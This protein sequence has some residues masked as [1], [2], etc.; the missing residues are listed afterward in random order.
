MIVFTHDIVFLKMLYDALNARGQEATAVTVYNSHYSAGTVRD[1]LPWAGMNTRARLG[2]LKC[3]AQYAAKVYETDGPQAYDPVAR[4]T[5]G[6]R[7]VPAPTREDPNGRILLRLPK[8]L[9]V[10]VAQAAARDGVSVNAFVTAAV[11]ERVG[12]TSARR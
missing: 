6:R 1:G 9:H 7:P 2:A 10:R 5:Y 8:S 12:M 11:A 3:D 4:T